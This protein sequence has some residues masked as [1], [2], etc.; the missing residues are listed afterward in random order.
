MRSSGS[1]MLTVNLCIVSA[2]LNTFALAFSV[3][4]IVVYDK[5]IGSNQ[6]TL[7]NVAVSAAILILF[8]DFI[9]KRLK[10]TLVGQI[11]SKFE[12]DLNEKVSKQLFLRK[13]RSSKSHTT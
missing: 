11:R 1:G 13:Y 12:A 7:L 6:H 9:A 3:F 2:L 8:F 5:V 10:A 4:V